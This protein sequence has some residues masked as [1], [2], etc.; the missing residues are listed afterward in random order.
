MTSAL[1]APA[2]AA[3]S[4][5]PRPAPREA[6]QPE[7]E[8]VD[9]AARPAPA[10]P[11]QLGLADEIELGPA[12]SCPECGIRLQWASGSVRWCGMCGYVLE[13]E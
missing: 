7:P 9:P 5:E 6:G 8:R 10:P 2:G 4:R 1:P 3:V 11:Y 13:A 12:V